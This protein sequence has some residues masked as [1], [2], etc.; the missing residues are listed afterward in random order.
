LV[1]V[2]TQDPT[3]T[4]LVVNPDTLEPCAKGEIGE[5]WIDAP[6]NALGYWQNEEAT[7]NTFGAYLA[8][9]TTGPFL[10]TGDLTYIDDAG[11]VFVTGRI[12]DMII[13]RGTNHYPQDIELTVEEAHPFARKGCVAAFALQSD[14]EE[15]LGVVTE[16]DTRDSSFDSDKVIS[17]IV[18]EV[19]AKHQISPHVVCLINAKT[20]GKTSSGKIQ[21]YHSRLGLLE[22][23]LEVVAQSRAL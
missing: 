17:A 13:I 4:L 9:G 14:G 16:V 18:K 3:H 12:K 8:D 21:R 11:E 19:A 2:G 10:R 5:L 23:T 15:L 20:I 7:Q 22:G 1:S 6:I